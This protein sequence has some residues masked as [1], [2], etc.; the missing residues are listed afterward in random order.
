MVCDR[1]KLIVY[2]KSVISR[3]EGIVQTQLARED[4][5]RVEKLCALAKTHDN[6]PDMEKD[7]MYIG[8]TKGDFRTHELSDPLKALMHAIFDFT[9]TGDAEK[10][11]SRIM[12]IWAAFHTLRLK[13]LVHCL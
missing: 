8:W 6:Y 13:V 5:S 11:D 4:L 10:Y 1:M 3:N 2:L 7:G 9:K 12:D